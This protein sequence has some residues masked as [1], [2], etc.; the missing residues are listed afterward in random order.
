M[1]CSQC[2]WYGMDNFN[3]ITWQNK[4][5]EWII[6]LGRAG[7]TTLLSRSDTGHSVFL[8]ILNYD[9][10]RARMK[11][12]D[13]HG[14]NGMRWMILMV[15]RDNDGFKW[16]F[17]RFTIMGSQAQVYN[18]FYSRFTRRVFTISSQSAFYYYF[19]NIH[20]DILFPVFFLLFYLQYAQGELDSGLTFISCATN[21][22][23]FP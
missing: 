8:R 5:K 18:S 12:W 16:C 15:P 19:Y 1:K 10:A 4:S 2:G 7:F 20:T 21:S 23:V 9:W 17:T 6:I 22:F 13:V 11:R 14:M 3:S